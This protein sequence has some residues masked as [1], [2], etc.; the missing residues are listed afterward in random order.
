MLP[1]R[2]FK[3]HFDYWFKDVSNRFGSYILY[4]TGDLCCEPGYQVWNHTQKVYEISFIVSGKGVFLVNND[5]YEVSSGMLFI[6]KIGEK[7]EIQSSSLDPLRFFYLGFDFANDIKNFQILRLKNFFDN[8]QNRYVCHVS[9][10]TEL[11]TK[12]L[13]EIKMGDSFSGKM[14][15]DYIDQILINTYR[16]FSQ[17]KYHVYAS[18]EKDV[19]NKL[20]YDIV[21]YIDTEIHNINGLTN[22]CEI[23]GYSYSHISHKFKDVMGESLKSYYDKK[24]F[25]KAKEMIS[26]DTSITEVSE[27]LGYKS[28]HAF[29]RA[30]RNFVGMAPTDY[31]KW[32]NENK[33]L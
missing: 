26:T 21:H 9:G 11:F 17:Q 8:I 2:R 29:S 31:K 7:H 30:F 12:L 19:N 28:I 27:V 10:M 16:S 24:R 13:I 32:V 1:N 15:E 3:F 18:E 22:L 20:V 4:Q 5:R 6:N 33:V 23:L 25:E 14:I